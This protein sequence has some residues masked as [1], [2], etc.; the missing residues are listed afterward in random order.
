MS[1]RYIKSLSHC[2]DLLFSIY[3]NFKFTLCRPFQIKYYLSSVHT[4]L[5]HTGSCTSKKI[6]CYYKIRIRTADTLRAFG[7]NFARSH[8]TDFT[9]HTRHSESTLRLL[10]VKSVKC[11]IYTELFHAKHHL[12]YSRIRS[13][14][15]HLLLRGEC[16]SVSTYSLYIVF[17]KCLFMAM[18]I[19][20]SVLIS[21]SMCMS[22]HR[23]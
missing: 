23:F 19:L 8:I 15:K 4:V 21:M 17:G 10:L 2:P 12:S 16:L 6:S 14:L 9:A 7:S 22:F 1:C 11:C 20:V 5:S 13:I 3:R 18:F